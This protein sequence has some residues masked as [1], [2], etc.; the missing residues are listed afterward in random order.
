MLYVAN[1]FIARGL[2]LSGF[3]RS[4]LR[5]PN[6]IWFWSYFEKVVWSPQ[7]IDISRVPLNIGFLLNLEYLELVTCYFS[8]P[9][10]TVLHVKLISSALVKID[11]SQWL[12]KIHRFTENGKAIRK[13][14]FAPYLTIDAIRQRK[15]FNREV[16]KKMISGWKI[17]GKF[18][19]L[20][21]V[22]WC[23]VFL[24]I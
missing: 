22:L 21:C 16:F 4:N 2:S 15:S 17:L 10:P 8:T 24:R 19:N 9:V 1:W 6:L 7:Y 14:W 12:W 20:K 13:N 23:L 18:Q 3:E 5:F 11:T